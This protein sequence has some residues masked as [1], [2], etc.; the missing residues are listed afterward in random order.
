MFH[1]NNTRVKYWPPQY[2]NFSFWLSLKTV[3]SLRIWR[4]RIREK[5][6]GKL[7]TTQLIKVH[8]EKIVDPF[9]LSD[10]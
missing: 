5:N 1:R 10:G 6:E 7:S 4:I 9:F 8:H 2:T 3:C